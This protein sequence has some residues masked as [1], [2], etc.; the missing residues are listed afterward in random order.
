[1][2]NEFYN[3]NIKEKFLKTVTD[4][5]K[6]LNTVLS[7]NKIFPFETQFNKD[8]SEFNEEQITHMIDSLEFNSYPTLSRFKLLLSD[9]VD[10]VISQGLCSCTDNLLRQVIKRY[11]FKNPIFNKYPKDPADLYDNLTIIFGS[12]DKDSQYISSFVFLC[13]AYLGF[14]D[15]E[16]LSLKKCDVDFQLFKIK[17][18]A[19]PNIFWKAI[20]NSTNTNI[21]IVRGGKSKDIPAEKKEFIIKYISNNFVKVVKENISKCKKNNENKNFINLLSLNSIRM[22]GFLYSCYINESNG[23]QLNLNYS[24]KCLYREYK[25][26]YWL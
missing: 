12:P 6:Y 15:E 5:Y 4:K 20:I 11:N 25:Q 23:K 9:Y 3:S 24:E 18:I 13:L 16:I 8:I 19:I 2:S 22:A 14:S 1:M 21:L 17:D 10:Y 7:F 26:A